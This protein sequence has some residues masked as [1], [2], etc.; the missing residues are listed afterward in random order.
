MQSYL[1][2]VSHYGFGWCVFAVALLIFFWLAPF[3]GAERAIPPAAAVPPPTTAVRRA[4]LT[5]VAA[6]ASILIVLPLLSA[7]LRMSHPEPPAA[8]PAVTL[9]PQPPW[10][11][12]PV[13]VSSAWLPI[14]PG[15]D[16]LQRRA[17]GSAAEQTVEVLGVGYRIQRQ[18]AE[19]VGES[20]SLTGDGLQA[21][22]EHIVG[23]TAGPFREAETADRAG[24]R[25]L[26]WWRYQVD[27]HNLTGPFTQQ[28]WYGINALVWQPPAGL[29]ALRTS[30]SS[31]CERARHTLQEFVA[32]TGLR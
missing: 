30:C 27:G 28:L 7:A 23:S 29:I 4:E 17:F 18:G 19:L 32:H 12:V 14:F 22:A 20:S 25:S 26:M 9:D 10:H 5:G 6:A 8:G 13:D 3:L 24:A 11:T 21:R 1:V 31:D 16:E 2:R 15:A